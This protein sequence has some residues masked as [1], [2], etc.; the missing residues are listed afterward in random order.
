[1]NNVKV[2]HTK[3][4]VMTHNNFTEAVTRK[5][6]NGKML[7]KYTAHPHKS[8]HTHM[9]IQQKPGGNNT[10]I[11]GQHRPSPQNPLYTFRPPTI[12]IR[13]GKWL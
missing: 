9:Q 10:E 8:T 12:G 7:Q 6:P 1:M 11:T 4:K 3:E 13:R 2:V 5:H